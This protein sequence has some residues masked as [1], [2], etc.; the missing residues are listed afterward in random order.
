MIAWTA[1]SAD[2]AFVQVVTL[3]LLISSCILT[4]R[5]LYRR[6]NHTSSILLYQFK[7]TLS[8]GHKTVNSKHYG[9][10]VGKTTV[11]SINI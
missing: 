11:M 7:L 1:F 5:H 10:E 3:S 2:L 8:S 9:N 4:S 6:M